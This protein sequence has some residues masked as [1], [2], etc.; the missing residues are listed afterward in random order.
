MI[1]SELPK[2]L[3][4]C[5]LNGPSYFALPTALVVSYFTLWE[6]YKAVMRG[7]LIQFS[8]HCKKERV[9]Q[10]ISLEKALETATISFKSNPSSSNRVALDRAR[11]ALDLAQTSEAKS[12][13]V[14]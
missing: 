7:H 14:V 4:I 3:K 11:V 1:C 12:S 2:A 9:A 6:T 5:F 8:T 13:S 10:I